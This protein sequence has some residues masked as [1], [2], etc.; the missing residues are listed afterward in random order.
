MKERLTSHDVGECDATC[1]RCASN[2]KATNAYFDWLAD[3]GLREDEFSYEQW[4]AGFAPEK[5]GSK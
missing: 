3:S 1:S 2:D 4:L 5:E